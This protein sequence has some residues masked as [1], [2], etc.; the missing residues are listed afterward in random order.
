MAKHRHDK[1]RYVPQPGE[2]IPGM[3]YPHQPKRPVIDWLL[4]QAANALAR[5]IDA[6]QVALA[7]FGDQLPELRDTAIA[8]VLRKRCAKRPE[9][10]AVANLF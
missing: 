3:H 8:I 1:S 6:N 10:R 5:G 4:G 7:F 2:K 9:F